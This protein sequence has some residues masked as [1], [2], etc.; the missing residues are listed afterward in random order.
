MSCL[1]HHVQTQ[2]ARWWYAWHHSLV[3]RVPADR[4]RFVC[5]DLGIDRNALLSSRLPLEDLNNLLFLVYSLGYTVRAGVHFKNG[6]CN[7]SSFG[8]TCVMPCA[9][10]GE[11]GSKVKVYCMCRGVGVGRKVPVSV[12]VHVRACDRAREPVAGLLPCL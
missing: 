7:I 10:G 2:H 11:H 4:P 8:Y 3:F 1:L 5:N 9:L 12:G 6:F